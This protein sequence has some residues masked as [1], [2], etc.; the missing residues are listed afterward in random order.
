M[1]FADPPVSKEM[2]YEISTADSPKMTKCSMTRGTITRKD[3]SLKLKQ[4]K[5]KLVSSDAEKVTS[6]AQSKIDTEDAEVERKSESLEKSSELEAM[7]VDEPAN[8][9]ETDYKANSHVTIIEDIQ[10]ME[11]IV[12][13]A[14]PNDP[15]STTFKDSQNSNVA[16]TDHIGTQDSETQQDIFDTSRDNI[17][18][19][20][21]NSSVDSIK[22]N[23]TDDSVIAALPTKD[24][25][26]A[27]ME[28]TVD[29]QNMTDMN[30]TVNTDEV[31]C[32]KLMRTS[33][34]AIEN[35]AEQDTLPATDSM[36]S[37]LISQD[38][39]SQKNNVEVE[40]EYLDS[41]L[42]IYPTLL[43]CVEP[44]DSIIGQLTYPTWEENLC[45]YFESRNICTIG[46]LARLSER[47]VNRLPVKGKSKIEHVKSVLQRFENMSMQQANRPSES[48]SNVTKVQRQLPVVE[49]PSIVPITS[50]IEMM[51]KIIS[52]T[53]LI[54]TPLNL[55]TEIFN[56]ARNKVD[57]TQFINNNAGVLSE[58]MYSGSFALPTLS[59]FRDIEQ[60][61]PTILIAQNPPAMSTNNVLYMQ[62]SPLTSFT[63]MYVIFYILISL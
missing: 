61:G 30:S 13:V 19:S 10:I 14:I 36:F 18:T 58:S 32:G 28:D 44:I 46:E 31:F 12:I 1:S 48:A 6:D 49:N 22:L 62:A 34:H 50:N 2:G 54:N 35:V 43:S 33:T 59:A 45:A 47:E 55:P 11:E 39:Q 25:N 38:T 41:T 20:I 51:P 7:D 63:N 60:P 40:P 29:V 9:P 8:A 16:P 26:S 27:N 23:I 42:S 53:A 21:Q 52:N 56:L 37:S 3:S 5:L 57:N 17:N 15:L 24:N 4:T